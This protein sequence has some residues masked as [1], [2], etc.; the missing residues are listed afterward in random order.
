MSELSEQT[1]T[2]LSD[3]IDEA[4]EEEGASE[5]DGTGFS[6]DADATGFEK[7]IGFNERRAYSMWQVARG[8]RRV[9]RLHGGQEWSNIQAAMDAVKDECMSEQLPVAIMALADGVLLGR[10]P[11]PVIR[12]Y[13]VLGK[14][15]DLFLIAGFR[16]EA[17]LMAFELSGDYDLVQGLKKYIT[18]SV[19]ATGASC[20]AV[21][22]GPSLVAPEEIF[23]VWMIAM[24]SV[25]I[26]LYVTGVKLG[27]VQEENELLE[28]IL[29]ASESTEEENKA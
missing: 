11:I 21:T 19:Y 10:K 28:G 27:Q 18:T 7:Y 29:A 3:L 17:E 13:Q 25:V 5:N 20:G 22:N 9:V 16:A 2:I 8:I 23:D 14:M 6:I 24:S 26:A 12:K 1:S 4:K 15:K